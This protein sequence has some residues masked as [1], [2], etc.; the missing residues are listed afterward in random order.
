MSA[1]ELLVRLEG[2]VKRYPAAADERPALQGVDL[3]IRHGEF[4]A[5]MGPS[6]SG[7]STLMNILGCLD[8]PTAGRYFLDGRDTSRLSPDALARLRNRTIG[9]VFQGFNLLPRVNAVDNVALPLLYA[10]LRLAERRRR[11]RELLERMD[12]GRFAESLPNQMSGG[13]Q[14][15][16]AIARALINDPQLLLA[17]EPTGNLDTHTS[18]AIMAL[19]TELN[20]TRGITVVLVTHESDIAACARR[21]VRFLD[22][23]IVQDLSKPR[24]D[25]QDEHGLIMNSSL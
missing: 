18:A 12:L 20:Q 11:A 8:V 23:R 21:L 7:K 13:Q 2:I 1:S 25:T 19:L 3:T 22:G 17:D 4:V 9:F 6:G 16:I 24:M 14:Q 15:R 5:I 10:G